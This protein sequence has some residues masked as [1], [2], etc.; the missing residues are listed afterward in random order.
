MELTIKLNE[1]DLGKGHV[2]DALRTLVHE[3]AGCSGQDCEH[4]EPTEA[5]EVAM[6][7]AP[8]PEVKKRKPRATKKKEEAAAPEMSEEEMRNVVRFF[9]NK[10][11]AEKAI[12]LLHRYAGLL[13]E[14]KPEDR[15]KLKADMEAYQ[16][17]DDDPLGV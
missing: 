10:H 5:P 7:A 4:E 17:E 16:P 6:E 15:P 12:E 2:R 9:R 14:L 13:T 1:D 3:M 8:E 11:G